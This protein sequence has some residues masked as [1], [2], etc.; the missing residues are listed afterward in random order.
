MQDIKE[1]VGD[2]KEA[3]AGE[4]PTKFK[5]VE[6]AIDEG[7]K[8]FAGAAK[9]LV[10]AHNH[11]WEVVLQGAAYAKSEEEQKKLKPAIKTAEL[12]AK[13]G[14]GGRPKHKGKAGGLSGA[15][16]GNLHN[17]YAPQ[18]QGAGQAVRRG[19]MGPAAPAVRYCYSCG[20]PGHFAKECPI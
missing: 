16:L 9:N 1:A 6:A 11:G 13:S 4:R 15:P 19:H 2:L 3:P 8:A 10:V 5:K 18:G 14:K 20:N 12:V 17:T 7:E